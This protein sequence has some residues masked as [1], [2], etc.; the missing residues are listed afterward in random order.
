MDTYNSSEGLRALRF[1]KAMAIGRGDVRQALGFVEGMHAWA[2]DRDAIVE[3][4]REAVGGMNVSD[5]GGGSNVAA[6]LMTAVTSRS[7]LQ[8]LPVHRVPPLLPSLVQTGRPVPYWV[9]ESKARRLSVGAFRRDPGLT[10]RSVNCLTV[11]TNEALADNSSDVERELLDDMVRV[12]VGAIDR[13]FLWR[14][15]TGDDATPR[16]VTAD[17][18][19]VDTGPS[20]V[21]E[22]DA[23]LRSAIEVLLAAGST[24]RSAYWC[25]GAGLAARLSLLRTSNGS[26]AYPSLTVNGGFL[27]GLPVLCAGADVDDFDSDAGGDDL[28]LLDAAEIRYSDAPPILKTSQNAMIEMDNMPAAATDTPTSASKSLVSMFQS[29]S[30]ALLCKLR[31]N[32]QFARQNRAAVIASVQV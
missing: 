22:L 17:A 19:V 28:A 2:H 14:G 4:L 15:N 5:V 23:A 11:A 32:W 20:T 16:S 27:A 24:L 8:R 25:L 7:L 26:A 29:E 30:T 21:D 13:A 1:L 3:C 9:S 31:V 6:D 10:L 12:C 18:V